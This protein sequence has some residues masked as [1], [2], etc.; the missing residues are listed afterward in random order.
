MTNP[1]KELRYRRW[2]LTVNNYTDAEIQQLEQLP[3]SYII[4]GRERGKKRDTPHLQ[5]YMEF[6]NAKTFSAI[7]KMMKKAHIEVSKGNAKQ[8]TDYCSKDG[9][10]ILQ[11]GEPFNQ[12]KRNDLIGI[13]DEI[14]KGLN[15][16]ELI[17]TESVK[18]L[19]GIKMAQT[20]AKWYEPERE[21]KAPTIIWRWGA[22][23]TGKTRW[24]YEN[25]TEVFRPISYKWFEGYD[26]HKVVLI[27]DLRDNFCT[28]DEFLRFTDIY[29]F[30]VE[31]KGSSRQFL[32][33]TIIITSPFHPKD[34]WKRNNE[35][36]NQLV[37]RMTEITEVK[38]Y[39]EVKEGNTNNLLDHNDSESEAD[40]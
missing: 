15:M 38:N 25:Y 26:A 40:I 11:R 1:K 37:R 23:G 6:V 10:V 35:D 17:E 32:A 12:G 36:T 28:Y 14:Q 27:D 30:R 8:N 18:S 29:P 22:T 4:A 20:L 39:T 7:K 3:T 13:K 19:Q 16:R 5:I 21:I 33:D 9:D 34:L 31:T 2:C 24:V